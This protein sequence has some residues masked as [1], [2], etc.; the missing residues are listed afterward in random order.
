MVGTHP[1]ATGWVPRGSGPED[2]EQTDQDPG[3]GCERA[4]DLAPRRGPALSW[5][6]GSRVARR[7][8]AHSP[9]TSFRW[10][11]TPSN[12][13]EVS[14]VIRLKEGPPIIARDLWCPWSTWWWRWA[15]RGQHGRVPPPGPGPVA[16]PGPVSA[17][18]RVM[19]TCDHGRT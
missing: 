9:L 15:G 19:D 11:D 5:A 12:K 16:G 3:D 14:G 1:A 17:G 18:D 8:L 7:T 6:P 10:I 13:R 4:N 2:L